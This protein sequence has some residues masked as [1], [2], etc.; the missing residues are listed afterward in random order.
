MLAN[1]YGFKTTANQI[2]FVGAVDGSDVGW[3]LGFMLNQTN[4]LET[5]PGLPFATRQ[6]STSAFV[7]ILFLCFIL[8]IASGA[9][10]VAYKFGSANGKRQ[11]HSPLLQMLNPPNP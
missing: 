10:L 9:Y 6:L 8:V 11:D 7:G 1:G 4:F 5:G 3:S 2:E